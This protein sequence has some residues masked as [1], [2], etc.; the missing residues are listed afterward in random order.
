MTDVESWLEQIGLGKYAGVFAENDVDFEALSELNDEELKELGVSLGHRK[1][2]QRELG[3]LSTAVATPVRPDVQETPEQGITGEAE[4]RH[5]TVMFSDLVGSTGRVTPGNL[6][7]R[8]S[9][10]RT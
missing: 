3:Q 5:L 9:R 7:P 6:P 1:K 10:N 2:L 8:C 4:R